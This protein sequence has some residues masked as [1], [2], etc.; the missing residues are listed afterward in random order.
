MIAPS[1]RQLNLLDFSATQSYLHQLKPDLVIHAAGKV[2]GIRTNMREPVI[3]LMDNL[4]GLL[5]RV[6]DESLFGQAAA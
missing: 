6:S 1:S 2:G 5:L 3:F 4:D